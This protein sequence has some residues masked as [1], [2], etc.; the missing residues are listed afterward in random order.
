MEWASFIGVVVLVAVFAV[1]VGNANADHSWGGYHWAR[2]MS[3]FTLKLGDNVNNSWNVY[4]AEA[5]ADWNPSEVLDTIIVAGKTNATRGRNTPKNCLPTSGQ[6]EVCNY[7]YGST[8]WLGVASIWISGTHITQGTVK[9]NDTYFNT[10]KYNTADWKGLVACQEV[11]HTFGL[12]HQDEIFNNYNLGT[13]MD[14]TNAPAGGWVGTF[15]YGPSNRYPNAHDFDELVLIYAHPDTTTT[16]NPFVVSAGADVDSND[17]RT[18]GR[19]THR[20]ADGRAS[21]YEQDLGN[22]KKVVRHVFWAEPRGHQR[23]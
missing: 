10:A 20:S 3:S 5:S 21:V 11:A 2:T 9:L 6:V 19:E 18:W 14:Y 7:K 8:G 1:S 12:D 13:C 15:D 23:D 22:G 16:V 17:P 4:L